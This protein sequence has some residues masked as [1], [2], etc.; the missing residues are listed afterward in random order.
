MNV[1]WSVHW[2]YNYQE[3]LALLKKP[4]SVHIIGA[5]C[6]WWELSTKDQ[7]KVIENIWRESH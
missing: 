6:K 7:K 5:Y 2:G 1:Q 3:L 4:S